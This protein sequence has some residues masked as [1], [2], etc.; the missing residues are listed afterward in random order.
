MF[1]YDNLG[2]PKE[3]QLV[4]I[5]G[6]ILSIKHGQNSVVELLMNRLPNSSQRRTQLSNKKSFK[7]QQMIDLSVNFEK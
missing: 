2:L 1:L 3:L 5:G 6:L 4:F 7:Q